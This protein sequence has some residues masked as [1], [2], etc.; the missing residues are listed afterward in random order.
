M[1]SSGEIKDFVEVEFRHA[2]MK[3]I[4]GTRN[5]VSKSSEVG[6]MECVRNQKSVFLRSTK[7][8]WKGVVLNMTRKV[9]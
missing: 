4:A 8:E 3:N 7:D 1:I 9:S 2:K 6:S 5:C